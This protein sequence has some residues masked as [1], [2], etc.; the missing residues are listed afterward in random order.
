MDVI[1]NN[2]IL[3]VVLGEKIGM[4]WIEFNFIYKFYLGYFFFLNGFIIGIIEWV[5]ILMD[6][7]QIFWEKFKDMFE[8]F[9]YVFYFNEILIILLFILKVMLDMVLKDFEFFLEYGFENLV[10]VYIFKDKVFLMSLMFN[11]FEGIYFLLMVLF[12]VF[13]GL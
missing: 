2:F 3:N 13:K 12:M 7:D 10:D 4:I 1:E 11:V 8:K 6:Y 9:F 5:N